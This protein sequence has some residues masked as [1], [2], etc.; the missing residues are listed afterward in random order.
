MT[1][2]GGA[3][4]MAADERGRGCDAA[5]SRISA[6]WCTR[7]V[8]VGPCMRRQHSNPYHHGQQCNGNSPTVAVLADA[9]YVKC[10]WKRNDAFDWEMNGH[11]PQTHPVSKA[12]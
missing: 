10:E 9:A 3:A 6:Y 7:I 4:N 11:I 8:S 2:S 5:T 1:S 12:R